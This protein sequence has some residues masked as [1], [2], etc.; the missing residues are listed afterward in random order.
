MASGGSD[1]DLVLKDKTNSSKPKTIRHRIHRSAVRPFFCCGSQLSLN[2]ITEVKACNIEADPADDDYEEVCNEGDDLLGMKTLHIDTAVTAHNLPPARD[3]PAR[4]RISK[5]PGKKI[6]SM[7]DKRRNKFWTLKSKGKMQISK[8]THFRS[9]SDLQSAR[10]EETK[11]VCMSYKRSNSDSDQDY[12]ENEHIHSINALVAND[13][14]TVR[15]G[16]G[17]RQETASLP[18]V[19]LD[20]LYP[21]NDIDEERIRQR[22]REMEQG[23]DIE[24]V[25]VYRKEN[26]SATAISGHSRFSSFP[27][28]AEGSLG[29]YPSYGAMGLLS[30]QQS[31]GITASC[32]SLASSQTCPWVLQN[33]GGS[34]P[35]H[36][37]TQVDYIH[38]LVPDLDKIVNSSFYWGVMDRYQAEKVIENKPEGTFL[39]RDSA[40]E[41]F[42]FSVSFRRYGRSLH[43]R[44]EQWNHNFSFDSRDP[45][46]YATNSVCGLIDHYKDP[47]CCMFFEPMLTLPLHRTF[48]F[49]LQHLARATICSRTTYDGI[50]L[51]SLPRALKEYLRVYHYKQKVRVRRFDNTA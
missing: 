18:V 20:E 21:I 39:L 7:A 12:G 2:S 47:S 50:S 43:A 33:P 46:V 42:L 16:T 17:G 48:P 14:V 35:Q 49:S 3:K 23:V 8:G 22:R 13:P 4:K 36:I 44:I 40:Q 32:G 10:K 30:D 34:H 37:H 25:W 19:N 6:G 28:G 24:N 41:E 45:G 31:L 1:K 5:V 51:L 11:C 38:Y 29:Q 27:N 26:D 15:N 9:A